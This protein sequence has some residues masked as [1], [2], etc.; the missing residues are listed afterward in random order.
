MDDLLTGSNS[1]K[2]LIH[3]RD[4][5][6]NILEQAHFPLHKLK[7]NNASVLLDK[8]ASRCEPQVKFD[9]CEASKTLGIHWFC[10]TDIF[11][12]KIVLN[13]PRKVTKRTVLSVTAQIFDPLGLVG[14]VIMKAKI[15]LQGLWCLK[16]EWD[17]SLPADLHSSWVEFVKGLASLSNLAVPRKVINIFPYRTI[18]LHGFCDASQLGYG[19]AIYVRVGD[20]KDNFETTLLCSKSKVAPLKTITLPRLELCGALLLARLIYKVKQV[21]NVEFSQEFLWCDSTIFLAWINSPP[22]SLKSFVANRISEIQSLTNPSNWNHVVSKNNA[23]DILSR[24]ANAEELLKSAIWFREPGFLKMPQHL[25]PSSTIQVDESEIP[26][27]QVTLTTI[28][29]HDSG[30][31]T[32]FLSRFSKFTTLQRVVARMLRFIKNCQTKVKEERVL[33]NY[34]TTEELKTATLTIAKI[35]Q[36]EEFPGDYCNL[37]NNKP[38]NNKSKLLSLNPI[39]DEFDIIRVGGRLTNAH[40]SK[41]TKNPI[42]LPKK[43]FVTK[44]LIIYEHQRQLHAGPQATLAALRQ[45]YWIISGKSAIRQVLHYCHNCFKVNPIITKPQMGNLPELRVKPGR[46]F[47][48]CGVDYAGPLLVKESR[49]RSKRLIKS[50]IAIFVCFVTKAVHIELVNDL[51]TSEFMAALRR[52]V[53]RRGLPK[54]IYS[55]NGTNFVGAKNELAELYAF[56]KNKNIQNDLQNIAAKE[57]IKWHFIPPRSPHMGGLWEINVKSVKGHLKRILGNSNLTSQEMNTLLIRIEACLNSR[58]ITPI[59][60]DPNDLQPL[61]PGHFLIGEPL[62]CFPEYDFTEVP[63]NR[64]AR[65]EFVERLRQQFWKRWTKEYLTQL[66]S[67]SK[68]KTDAVTT[69][70]LDIGKMVVL[71]EDNLPPLQWKIGRIVETHPGD[72][73]KIRVVTVRTAQGTLKRAARKVCVVPV[74]TN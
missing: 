61:T 31:K 64:L 28:D 55:D 25:W 41:E 67:R 63:I 9:K 16:L 24:G 26:E 20:D 15:I 66:Q 6:I 27:K 72:D 50:Y 60:S 8:E 51:S 49:G 42:L 19:A 1:L 35:V 2:D 21:F 70:S 34:L 65:W 10:N 29:D 45:R 4:S 12:Y 58:P 32:D 37:K 56:V 62:N 7:S 68:W 17:E 57:G 5:V 74:E 22:N 44:L 23:A 47:L 3:I 36:R 43:H 18:E 40:L 73:G 13:L 30:S 53:G 71:A 69:G 11:T 54:D 48:S 14:P 33:Y 46:A 38:L 39:I 52:F 59:S